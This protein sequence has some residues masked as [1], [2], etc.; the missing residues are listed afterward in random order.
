VIVK[1]HMEQ[2][3]E[4]WFAVRRGRPTA[5][6]FKRILTAKKCALAAG[7]FEY[8]DEL[9]AECFFPEFV[10][11]EGNKW[12]DRGNELEPVARESFESISGADV[13][14]VGFCTRNDELVG[15]SPDGLIVD[16]GGDYVSGLEIKCPAP[17]KHVQYIRKGELPD[18][19]KAQVHGGMAVTGLNEWHFFSFCPGVQPLWLPVQRDDFTETL[20]EALDT[21]IAEYAVTRE[22]LLP[23]LQLPTS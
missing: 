16:T 22:E 6:Q 10:E 9:I 19:Y 1:E 7:R 20:S 23:M 21:F 3:S 2:G 15:C 14:Q 5:S 18:E 4:E 12:T 8:M 11:F 13:H 17:R